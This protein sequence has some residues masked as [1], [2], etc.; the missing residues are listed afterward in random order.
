MIRTRVIELRSEMDN[1]ILLSLYNRLILIMT[2]PLLLY[3]TNTWLAYIIAQRYYGCEHYAWCNPSFNSKT[4]PPT[5]YSTP[6]TSSPGEIYMSLL[7]EVQRA[8]RNSTKIKQNK[9]GILKG[10][11][12]KKRA[13][14]INSRQQAEIAA[15]VECAEIQEFRPLVF[16]IPY[17][18]VVDLL[19]KVPIRNRAHPLS[20]EYIID[21]LPRECFDIIDFSRG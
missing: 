17:S 19:K 4:S 8:D 14:V 11:V 18:I 16:I 12:Y 15:V 13:G 6:P 5:D 9:L 21:R 3:S 7:A 2:N 1:N 10:A 20:D